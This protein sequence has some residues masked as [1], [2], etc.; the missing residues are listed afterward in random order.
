LSQLS[1]QPSG[2]NSETP[3][4]SVVDAT[5]EAVNACCVQPLSG[6][7]LTQGEDDNITE[8]DIKDLF[9]SVDNP[10]KHTTAM[11]SYI[12]F[13]VTTKVCL[14]PLIISSSLLLVL[15]SQTTRS[16][17]ESSEFQVRRRYNDFIWLRQRLE[18]T[19][20]TLLVPVS[21]DFLASTFTDIFVPPQ[22]LPEKHS[23]KRF[24]RFNQEFVRM[25]MH[26]LHIFMQRIAE[27]PVL[28]FNK[29][30]KTFLSAKQSVWCFVSLCF[31]I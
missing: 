19:Q 15:L 26:A 16:D 2:N 9:V 28:S 11:E 1:P 5:R 23:L 6:L 21:R 29:N 8:T 13:R 31:P 12:T 27:H 14:L 30:F 17:Y 22:P 25:R 4:K 10:E 20:P 18:E 7:S 3:P 24:D